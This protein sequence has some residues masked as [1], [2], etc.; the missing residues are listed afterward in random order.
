MCKTTNTEQL[1]SKMKVG[2]IVPVFNDT[3]VKRALSSIFFQK[4][5]HE[6]YTIVVDGK[7][8]DGTLQILD[9]YKD[10]IKI[11]SEPDDGVYHAM[12]KGLKH[13]LNNSCEIIHFLSANDFYSSPFTIHDVVNN[14]RKGQIEILYGD[15][16]YIN[17]NKKIVRKW[18][19]RKHKRFKWYLGWTPPHSCFFARR[20]NYE[21]HGSFD[22]QWKIAADY[23]LMLRFLFKKRATC[24]YINKPLVIM[25]T[26]GMSNKL[27]GIIRAN[28]E[29]FKICVKNKMIISLLIPFFK[30]ARKPIQIIL[31]KLT[32]AK[33][34]EDSFKYQKTSI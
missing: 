5:D 11:I 28:I 16:L 15:I 13:A 27:T 6:I 34:I 8:T 23:E 18:V 33:F 12:N 26:G 32:K 24:E 25:S 20:P 31:P 30:L 22:V 19:A 2:I 14:F 29:V 10:R 1:G 7:S 17:K 21:K 9:Q 4:G 3:R